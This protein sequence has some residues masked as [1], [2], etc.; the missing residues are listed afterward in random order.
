MQEVSLTCW[1]YA[2]REK[3]SARWQW[4]SRPRLTRWLES[5]PATGLPMM[6]DAVRSSSCH[7]PSCEISLVTNRHDGACSPNADDSSC[8]RLE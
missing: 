2:S 7:K 4:E 3:G 1:W 8:P 5:S 6:A